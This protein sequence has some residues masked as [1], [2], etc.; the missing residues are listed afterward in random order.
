M[1]IKGIDVSAYQG[2]IDWKTVANYGMGFVI[3]RVTEQD[4]QAD[5]TFETN[6]NGCVNYQIPVGVYKYSYAKTTAQAITEANAVLKVLNGRKLDFPVFYDLEWSEQRSLGKAAVE[7]IAKAFLDKIES[8][9]YKVGIYCN[10]DW[11]NNVLSN[12]LKQYDLWI[13]SY[14]SNDNGTLQE[15]LRPS[16][17]I[18]WQYSSKATIPG[19]NAKVDRNVFYKDY[20]STGNNNQGGGSSSMNKSQIVQKVID[21]AVDFATRMAADNSHGYSQGIRSLYNITNPTSFDCSSLVCTAYYYA[22][23]KNGI[24]PTPKDLGCS[25]TGNMMNLT[26]CGFE[27]VATNQTAH[28]Q[29]QKGDIELNVDYHTAMAIDNNNIVH[30]RSSE[31]TSDTRDGS[32]NEIRTQPWY[33]YSHK[34]DYRLRFTGKG[35]NF[36]SGSN[37]NV[38]G[39]SGSSSKAWIEKGDSGS[40]VKTM[41]TM[42]NKIGFDCGSA[43][44]EFG[45]NT[46]KA[47]RAFQKAYGLT[48]DGQYGSN[49]KKTLEAAYNALDGASKMES[50]DKGICIANTQL[51]G[52]VY[53]NGTH[54]KTYKKGTWLHPFLKKQDAQKRWWFACKVDGIIQWFSS[55]GFNGWIKDTVGWWYVLKGY[56]YYKS[57][58][59]RIR[60]LWYE[61]DAKG[62]RKESCWSTYKGRKRYLKADGSMAHGETLT[63]NGKKYQFEEGGGVKEL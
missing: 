1:E 8:S 43:D 51:I 6:Y 60:G 5:S 50:D 15:R 39:S 13:A 14:P 63:I 31:G 17:G 49:S 41:Q 45:A 44:G 56:K 10:M 28:A 35:V 57:E 48:V 3:L 55:T 32:G 26:R 47:V 16:V 33:L 52:R 46:D 18:G 38:P 53:P 24:T 34:W 11:Y 40:D 62:Y 29:M 42:L 61:F 12:T 30:A 19:I 22:F 58:W 21:D 4:N 20:S 25:Y 54:L 37:I 23:K 9:G 59:R 2:V 7:K 36:G 27:I